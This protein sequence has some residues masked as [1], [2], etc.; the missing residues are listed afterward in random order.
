MMYR[1]LSDGLII[2]KSAIN[3]LGLFTTK[4]LK[5]DLNLGITHVAMDGFENGYNRTPLGGFYN[6]SNSPNCIVYN[7]SPGSN[8][9]PVYKYFMTLRKILPEEEL[10]AKYTL[11]EVKK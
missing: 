9:R 8:G 2:Q 10:T 11:Y 5:K 6:H 3:G 1:P 4:E 7:S